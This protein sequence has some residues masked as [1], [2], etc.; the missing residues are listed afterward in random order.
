MASERPAYATGNGFVVHQN[1]RRLSAADCEEIRRYL[2]RQIANPSRS[3][4]SN[5][6]L[7]ERLAQLDA[8]IA[9]SWPA[10]QKAAAE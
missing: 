6:W 4:D 7:K 9:A 2:Q 10:E 1:G 8:A 5:R 3:D